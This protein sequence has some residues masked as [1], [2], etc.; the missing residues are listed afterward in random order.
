M[1]KIAYILFIFLACVACSKSKEPNPCVGIPQS[2]AEFR[3]YETNYY[4]YAYKNYYDQ[5]KFRDEVNFE[6]LD[7]T[8]DSYEWKVGVDP[9]KFSKRKF[10]LSFLNTGEYNITLKIRKKKG[11]YSCFINDDS[12]KT[13]SKKIKIIG[14]KNQLLVGGW[15]GVDTANVKDTFTVM[16]G[17]WYVSIGI[18]PDIYIKNYPNGCLDTTYY[19]IS[20]STYKLYAKPRRADF[21]ACTLGS[22]VVHVS[23]NKNEDT[24]IILKL[25]Y[26]TSKIQGKFIG[27]KQ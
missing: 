24:L 11:T 20:K 14:Q 3:T 7:S 12:I 19:Q 6:A 2:T 16:I 18:I 27:I 1:R 5:D 25:H 21:K 26:L 10:G 15:R 13:Y 9:R 17:N 22:S 8:A 23:V 4:S